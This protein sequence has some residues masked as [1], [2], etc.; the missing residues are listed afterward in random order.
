MVEEKVPKGEYVLIV[1]GKIHR[2]L[3][4]E[5]KKDGSLFPWKNI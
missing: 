3:K 2:R 4:R 1:E 5:K